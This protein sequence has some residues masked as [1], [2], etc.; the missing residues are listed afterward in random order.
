M[1]EAVCEGI[2]TI[3]HA[4]TFSKGYETAI[5]DMVRMADRKR[6]EEEGLASKGHDLPYFPELDGGG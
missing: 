6:R 4:V 1:G 5:A 3:Q 2:A